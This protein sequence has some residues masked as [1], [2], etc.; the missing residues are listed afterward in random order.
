MPEPKQGHLRPEA[1][2]VDKE[3]EDEN[4]WRYDL[5]QR[6]AQKH[7]K[8]SEE[9]KEKVARFVDDQINV[10]HHRELTTIEDEVKADW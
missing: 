10:I 6:T 8:P 3:V 4:A 5:H 2:V 9:A 1:V 7:H